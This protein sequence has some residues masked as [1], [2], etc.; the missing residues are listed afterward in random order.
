M[1]DRFTTDALVAAWG[2]QGAPAG[3][4]R[5]QRVRWLSEVATA[6]LEGRTAT[7][8]ASLYVGG[9][10]AQWL[11]TGGDLSRDFLQ[12]VKPK[13]RHTAS[14]IWRQ[15]QVHRDERQQADDASRCD[16]QTDGERNGA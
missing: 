12:V 4:D 3:L 14:Y 13:S 11:E 5:A 9:A 2:A 7:R 8:E 10:I 16:P 6:L 15:M 1:Q